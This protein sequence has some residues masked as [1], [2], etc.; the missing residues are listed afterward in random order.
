MSPLA[1]DANTL[2]GITPLKKSAIPGSGPDAVC[3]DPRKRGLQAPRS[4]ASKREQLGQH[5]DRHRPEHGR[6][7][8]DDHHPQHRPAGDPPA[9]AASLLLA[10]PTTSKV[11]TSGM[12]VIF[13]AF[14]HSAP[15]KLATAT[16]ADAPA[17]APKASPA[18]SA[19][20]A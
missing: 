12:T 15:M 7:G 4:L 1:A 16:P 9:A 20:R 18:M 5:D 11:T 3:L 8:A 19:A 14:S 10:M 13:S 2:S 6:G 17:S